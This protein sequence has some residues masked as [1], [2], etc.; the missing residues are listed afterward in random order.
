MEVTVVTA[1]RSLGIGHGL[2]YDAG[3]K[4]VSTGSIVRVPLR[5]TIVE[6]I[7]TGIVEARAAKPFPLK[8]IGEVLG[9]QPLL[10][11]AQL[12]TAAWMSDYY[13]CS[14]R[15]ALGAFLPAPPWSK[16]LPK[17]D[18]EAATTKPVRA[19][20]PKLSH[21][22]R[23]AVDQIRG[24][25]KPALLFGVTG[26]GKT[27]VYAELIADAIDAGKQALLL[28]PEILL[29]EHVIERAEAIV[30]RERIAILHSRLTP[31]QRRKAW[32]AIRSGEIALTI[33]S[34]SALFSPFPNLGLVVIDEEHE[35][36]YKNEQSPRYHA[37]ETA[38]ALC[39]FAKATLVLGSATP[40][41]EAWSRAKTGLYTLARL[42]E[43]FA[44]RPMPAVRIVDLAETAF[45]KHY[46]FSAQLIDALQKRVAA[47]EQSVL[48]LNRRGAASALMCMHCRRRVVSP[49][50]ELP[51][52]VHHHDD[53]RPYLLDHQTGARAHV[54]E[55]CPGCGAA[56]LKEVGAGTQKIETL[57]KQLVPG[58]VVVRADSDTLKKPEEM[59][60]VLSAMRQRKADILVG[61]QSVV[62]GLDLPGVSL[63]AVLVADVGL[64]LPH[65]R[66]GERIMQLLTQLSG[67][68]GR[69]DP[70]EVI[71]QTFRPAAP[72]VVLASKHDSETYL[73][74]E[75]KLRIAAGYPPF[76]KMIRLL[77][78]GDDS[79]KRAQ[80][81]REA[82]AQA[83]FNAGN[84][85]KC[86]AA[87]TLF[88][89]GKEWHVLLKGSN[90]RVLLP[91]LPLT[92][93]S[94][95]VDPIETA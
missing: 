26:S 63:A 29:T 71:I 24:S 38:E 76:T 31:A 68:S 23:A 89:K 27:E 79:Q 74:N 7:V 45:G 10:T 84:D 5:K 64:S 4:I 43:R 90:P 34:R 87:P 70:G 51:F 59:K 94:V 37:R 92:G 17:A 49:S 55:V 14:P 95:D 25:D 8:E 41:V 62:K 81:L 2:T 80:N 73:D 44:S 19:T 22:Q 16:L 35:W 40:S 85:C 72:E 56:E 15:Q 53:G 66:A 36:T 58:A 86:T 52:T 61:T 11:E 57:L 6:G 88:G 48:F 28:V 12:Q 9:D 42:P 32:R 82:A 13:F 54:P 18:E 77:V 83:A 46:P 91:S 1:S 78:R 65:F 30:P 75:L 21:E 93:V 67:R 60:Q 33:G 47:K 39:R 20:R 69:V 3:S 50:S